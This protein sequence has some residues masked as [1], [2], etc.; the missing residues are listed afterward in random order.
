MSASSSTVFQRKQRTVQIDDDQRISIAKELK[1]RIEKAF[2]QTKVQNLYSPNLVLS[3]EQ[4]DKLCI[5]SEKIVNDR[6]ID[7][8]LDLLNLT[9]LL[10]FMLL[11][12]PQ[13]NIEAKDL[14]W[15]DES[16]DFT[17][18]NGYFKDPH[19]KSLIVSSIIL[20]SIS[21]L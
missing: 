10:L 3:E 4:L 1:E 21:I 9:G 12:R 16:N 8:S 6:T 11:S 7:K 5:L 20:K 15:I 19:V 13:P 18:L 14:A 2:T 17:D